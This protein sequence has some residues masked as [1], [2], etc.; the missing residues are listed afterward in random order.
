MFPT[1]PY[2]T[3]RGAPVSGTPHSGMDSQAPMGNVA[4]GQCTNRCGRPGSRYGSGG[5]MRRMRWYRRHVSNTR[6]SRNAGHSCAQR[7]P[8][9]SFRNHRVRH[10]HVEV[11]QRYA[12]AL[13]DR[14]P[15]RLTRRKHSCAT[16]RRLQQTRQQDQRPTVAW[17]SVSVRHVCN[18]KRPGAAH[19]LGP[20]TR[21]QLWHS[22]NQHLRRG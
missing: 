14:T 7:V 17:E 1:Q 20:R 3:P 6:Q 10:C 9:R 22:C 11:V 13:A 15:L 12:T 16:W 21:A 19:V 8:L 18:G 5:T 2:Q 4:C